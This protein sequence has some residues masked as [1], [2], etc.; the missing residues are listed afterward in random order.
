MDNNDIL[1]RIRY[2]FDINDTTMMNTFELGGIQATRAQISSWL[3]KDIDPDYVAMP[4]FQ[5]SAFLNGFIIDKRGKR[6][7]P[8]PIPERQLSN[9]MVLRKLKIALNLKDTDMLELLML[10]GIKISK[11]ELSALFRKPGQKQFR[12]CKDQFLRNFLKGMQMKYREN[13]SL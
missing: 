2:A 9:N 13:K 11:H 8:N 7:G 3:K 4:A 10:A 6:E 5:L 1:R 12:E